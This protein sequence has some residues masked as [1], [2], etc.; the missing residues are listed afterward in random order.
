MRHIKIVCTIGPSSQNKDV[1]IQIR[2]YSD[3]IYIS[4][5]L[6]KVYYKSCHLEDEK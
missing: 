3:K 1:L 4:D 5:D 6:I 2:R